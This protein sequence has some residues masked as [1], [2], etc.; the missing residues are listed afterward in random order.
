MENIW[1]TALSTIAHGGILWKWKTSGMD[2]HHPA[3]TSLTP[4]IHPSRFR[5][6]ITKRGPKRGITETY[7]DVFFP[8]ESKSLCL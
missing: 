4:A 8:L 1:E 5:W 6:Y 3:L 7:S 2:R